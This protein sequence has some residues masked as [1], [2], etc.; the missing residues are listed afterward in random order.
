MRVSLFLGTDVSINIVHSLEKSKV[1]ILFLKL[2]YF[3]WFCWQLYIRNVFLN[4]FF[5]VI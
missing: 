3:S 5:E 1:H 4:R 2:Y